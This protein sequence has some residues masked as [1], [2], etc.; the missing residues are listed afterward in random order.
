MTVRALREPPM[1]TWWTFNEDRRQAPG[2]RITG[3]GADLV[4]QLAV[5][6]LPIYGKPPTMGLLIR[7]HVHEDGSETVGIAHM[8]WKEPS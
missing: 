8:R 3:E 5:Q 7:V 2:A 4:Y 6:P 1:A